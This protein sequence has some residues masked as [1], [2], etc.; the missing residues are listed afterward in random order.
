[1]NKEQ[2]KKYCSNSCTREELNSVLEWFE[3]SAMT[4]EGKSLLLNLWDELPEE[5]SNIDINFDS[6]LYKIHHEVNL[7]QSKKLLQ[8]SDQNI[9]KYKRR[10]R[11]RINLM[12]AAAI[13]LLPVLGFG[14]FY[15]LKYQSIKHIQTSVNQVCNEVFSSVDA[16]TKVV[17]PDGS[18]VW[19]NHSS[20]LK[21]PAMFQGESR[22]VELSGEGYFEVAHNS[23]IPFIVKAGDVQ[24]KATGTTFNV[25]AYPD[26]ERIETSL[27]NGK[28]ELQR[29]DSDG[30]VIPMIKMKPKEIAFFQKNNNEV[31]TLA[32]DD[33]RYFSWKSGKLVFNKEPMGDV[34]KKL[35]RWF[36]VDIKVQDPR[37]LELTYT[38]TFENETLPQ[39]MELIAMVSPVTYSISN[40]NETS[41]GIFS[42]RKVILTYKKN[43]N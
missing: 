27:I 31:S 22:N 43:A 21:Y 15:S 7:T 18:S 17:L 37:L 24:I 12:K 28:V 33:D 42:K 26:E 35:G 34:V 2:L 38:A 9:V 39:V 10:E 8:I 16:I 1:M 3:K 32:I 6:L 13:L 11:F 25:M 23:K 40:R 30:K 36:N 29:I 41:P 5:D 14:L 4:P 19:L 20:S